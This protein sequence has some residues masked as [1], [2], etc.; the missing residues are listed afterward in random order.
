[1]TLPE[2]PLVSIIIPS[3]NQGRYIRETID[4]VLSQDYRPIEVLVFDGASKDDT[5]AVLQSYDAPELQWWSEPDRGV[6]DAVNKGLARA[7]GELVAI[8]SSDDVYV[9]GALSAAVSAFLETP[10]LGLVYGD[11]EYIDA[12]SRSRGRTQ[13]PPFSLHDYVGKLT[14]IPQ[15]AAFFA[16]EAMKIAGEWRHDIS[17]AA[18]AEFY[19]RI[20]MRFAVKKIDRILAR[21]RHHDEQR[22][23]AAVRIQRDWQAAIEP[24]TRSKDR[25][26]RRYA[27]SGI[28]LTRIRYTPDT[29]WVRRTI[30]AYHALLIN[31]AVIRSPDFRAIRDLLPG[32]YPIWRLL[33][34]IKRR[35]GFAPRS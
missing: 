6:V 5:V 22:D 9:P 32:R 18:D 28:D 20:A 3:Y 23:T 10:G 26:I 29:Q 19:L 16:A 12:E 27:R 13:L 15:P 21:Y 2:W 4:S 14:Y 24:L 35:L 30:A 25:R 34:K 7:R 1:M 17:Y 11:V 33:S 8:Q 31:P